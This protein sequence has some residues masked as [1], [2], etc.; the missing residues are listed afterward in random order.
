MFA[1]PKHDYTRLLLSAI[2]LPDPD[3]KLEPLNR[4][5]LNLA[6]L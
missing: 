5:E 2:P 4:A 3:E 6:E 1:N